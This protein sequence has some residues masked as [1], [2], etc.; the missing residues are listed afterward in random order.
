LIGV[1]ALE[2]DRLERHAQVR[3]RRARVCPVLLP[4]ALALRGGRLLVLEPNTQVEGAAALALI[5]EERE[6]DGRVDAAREKHRHLLRRVGPRLRRRLPSRHI[7]RVAG[8]AGAA[9]ARRVG[10]GAGVGCE[11]RA[12]EPEDAVEP[13]EA[14]WCEHAGQA[15]RPGDLGRA[16]PVERRRRLAAHA[17][18]EQRDDAAR[19]GRVG[20]GAHVEGRAV[21]RAAPR[22]EHV[23]D[24]GAPRHARLRGEH[25]ER[26][27]ELRQALA[28][29]DEAEEAL[30]PVG[31]G[32]ERGCEPHQPFRQR[33]RQRGRLQRAR[34]EW[35]A[36]ARQREHRGRASTTSANI[37]A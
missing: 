36:R 13:V 25:C 16:Q 9:A 27:I 35:R 6:R 4:W 24:R 15:R 12:Q 2:R 26:L 23:H 33:P 14:R 17:A 21:G 18:R 32:P 7:S 19:E 31:R 22:R 34:R 20:G 29:A 1:L 3:A 30:A 5:E 28:D 10:V 8:A 11:L 37:S